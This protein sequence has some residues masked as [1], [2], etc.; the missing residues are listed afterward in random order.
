MEGMS[1]GYDSWGA[2]GTT[3][4]ETHMTIGEAFVRLVRR[5]TTDSTHR[6]LS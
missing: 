6:Q 4:R 3:G 1:S 5:G 2:D